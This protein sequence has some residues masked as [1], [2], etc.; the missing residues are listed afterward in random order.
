MA[1]HAFIIVW[2][3]AEVFY[4]GYMVFV[5]L[6]PEGAVGRPLWGRAQEV[7]FEDMVTRRL[8][9]IEC[10]LATA[11]LAVYLAVTEMAPRLWRGRGRPV[12]GGGAALLCAIG[13]G[14]LLAAPA[15]AQV[16]EGAE[17]SSKG[18]IEMPP[19]T[20]GSYTVASGIGTGRSWGRPEL[21]RFLVIAA[22]EWARRHPD[23][24]RLRIGDMSK[25]DGSNFPPHKTH[26][27]GLTLD[28][29]TR[30]K[31]ICNIKWKDQQLTAELAQLLQDL[32]ARQIL[33]NHETV[34]EQV[35]VCQAYPKHDGHFHVVID[36]KR[37]PNDLGPV[38]MPVAS[39]KDGG[40]AGW[41]QFGKPRRTPPVGD[42][43]RERARGEGLRLAWHYIGESR[44]WQQRYR[45]ELQGEGGTTTSAFDSGE[46]ESR[47][48][49][50]LL[51]GEWAHG[52]AFRW[53][54]T[55][56][57][58]DDTTQTTGWQAAGIDLQAPVLEAKA[59]VMAG[60]PVP[61]GTKPT[62][63]WSY[64]DASLQARWRIEARKLRSRRGAVMAEGVGKAD[65]AESLHEL[66]KGSYEW[67]VVAEDAAGNEA[68]GAWTEFRV[69]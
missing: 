54:V 37:V 31:N 32:G 56:W 7:P 66:P 51:E 57:G 41:A 27:D 55:V 11:G 19:S 21:I 9:A 42:K 17:V 59:P 48:T 58:A 60:T 36:P 61:V 15:T 1:L 18:Y 3:A 26:K 35:D 44:G 30:P 2:F 22:R 5:V 28:L 25:P 49:F 10:W 4:A 53:R 47:R 68:E 8:Y 20:D 40:A 50:H 64:K 34:I 46:V 14:L 23:G 43:A 29:T 6:A 38:L 33:Y 12:G 69:E 13:L 52:Q 67:R 16:P 62:F 63:R 24:P 45:V 65:E 39:L